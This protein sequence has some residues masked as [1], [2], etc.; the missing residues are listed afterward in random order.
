MRILHARCPTHAP[1]VHTAEVLVTTD[2][3]KHATVTVP[4]TLIVPAYQ[5]GL[6]SGGDSYVDTADD[7]WLPDQ[8]YA[9]TEWGW[10]GLVDRTR[11]KLVQIR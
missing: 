9:E 5:M 8:H 6:R 7:W 4:I 10:T 1:G 11:T 2:A 3:A